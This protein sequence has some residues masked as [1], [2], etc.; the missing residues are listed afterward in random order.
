LRAKSFEIFDRFGAPNRAKVVEVGKSQPVRAHVDLDIVQTRSPRPNTT[1]AQLER[2]H[3]RQ[4]GH[5]VWA[6]IR[7]L[8]S[9]RKK[10]LD[11]VHGHG[12]LPSQTIETRTIKPPMRLVYAV[13]HYPRHLSARELGKMFS[14]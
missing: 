10:R 7:W 14:M 4:F 6:S 12:M 9:C 2:D 1:P 3:S 13:N 8:P 5:V 11:H